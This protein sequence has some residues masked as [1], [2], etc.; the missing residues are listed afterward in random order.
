MKRRKYETAV[1]EQGIESFL[2]N[3]EEWLLGAERPPPDVTVN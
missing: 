3:V 1:S 2:E